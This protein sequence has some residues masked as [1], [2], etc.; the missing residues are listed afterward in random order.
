MLRR[1]RGQRQSADGPHAL[2]TVRLLELLLL[3]ELG[4]A[5]HVVDDARLGDL[6]DEV[7][8]Q[9]ALAAE[10]ALGERHVLLGLAVER[11]VL[12]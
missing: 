2:V 5:E 4:K 6:L 7:L 12:D 9:L 3:L 11:R 1:Q 8:G 10:L